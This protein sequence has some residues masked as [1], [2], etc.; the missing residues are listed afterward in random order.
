MSMIVVG[1]VVF[2]VIHRVVQDTGVYLVILHEQPNFPGD[3]EYPR[4]KVEVDVVFGNIA[5]HAVSFI[6]LA[7]FFVLNM[8]QR[9]TV[10]FRLCC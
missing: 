5:W 1:T 9:L 10:R 8:A 3:L 6:A 4:I 7:E 2:L